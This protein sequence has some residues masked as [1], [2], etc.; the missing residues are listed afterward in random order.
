MIDSNYKKI[1]FVLLIIL[2]L[3]LVVTI[4]KITLGM[5]T[6]S[7]SIT[8]DGYHSLSDGLNNVIG[9]IALS[10][11]FKPADVNHPYGH[12]K[13][14]TI[15]SLFIGF[16]LLVMGFNILK[17]NITHFNSSDNLNISP[18]ALGIMIATMCINIFVTRYELKKGKE[19][20]SSFLISD[21]KHTQSDVYITISVIIS[22]VAIKFFHL[23]VYF[24]NIMSFFVVFFI[25]KAGIEII[26]ETTKVLLDTKLINPKEIEKIVLSFDEVQQ[27]H[28]IKSRGYEDQGFVELHIHVDPNMSVLQA[29]RLDHAIENKI[30]SELDEKLSVIVH[31]EP[32]G[33]EQ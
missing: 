6:N 12:K 4:T 3:N 17:T 13:I 23:P 10:L 2:V 26:K 16:I 27:C 19:L 18:L 33:H 9:V 1:K 31:I 21:A 14:E 29:H 15:S 25:I 22:L 11:A 32:I 20:N 24:D 8:A 7:S 30:N 5:L 28:M